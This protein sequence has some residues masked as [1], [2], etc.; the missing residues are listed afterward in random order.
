[1]KLYE[2]LSSCFGYGWDIKLDVTEHKKFD[3]E[4]VR[5]VSIRHDIV[6]KEYHMRLLGGRYGQLATIKT[7]SKNAI[8]WYTNYLTILVNNNE[9]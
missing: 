5:F 3:V 4:K 7:D 9:Q 2:S 8:D 6:A 1:M